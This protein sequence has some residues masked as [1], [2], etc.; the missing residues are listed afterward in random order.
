[1]PQLVYWAVAAEPSAAAVALVLSIFCAIQL[2][3]ALGFE[4]RVPPVALRPSTSLLVALNAVVVGGLGALFIAED[5]G[6]RAA[7]IWLAGLAIAHAALGMASLRYPR[8]A[9]EI[10]FLLLGAAMIG[11]DTAFAFLVD[12]PALAVGWAASAVVLAAVARRLDERG[13][14]LRLPLAGQLALALAHALFID[15]PPSALGTGPEDLAGAAAAVLAVAFGAFAC[16]RLAW[17]E[18]DDM[19]AVLD[20]VSIAAAAYVTAFVLDGTPLVLA[21]AAQAVALAELGRRVDDRIARLASLPFL[22]L[23][24]GHVLV[25]EAPPT[26]LVYG[27]DDLGATAL[28]LGAVAA[29]A[30]RSWQAWRADSAA[31]RTGL[32]AF[33]GLCLLY[34]ASV[35]VVE[36]FQPGS[37]A[38][39]TG[40]E[41]GVRQQGQALLSAL[42]TLSGLA[43]LWV[44]LRR[45]VRELRLAGF[46]LLAIATT[47][48]FLYDLST[49]SSA[50]RVVSF[51]AVGLLLL[52]AALAY[53]RL[54]PAPT[55]SR[56][57]S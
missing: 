22:V 51:I 47:K 6:M 56:A 27:V 50:W 26:A 10:G 11:A 44:G 55:A 53:Q 31:V 30:A 45:G 17:T 40:L 46:G 39:E 19:R 32:A 24:A 28:A 54:R 21:W 52:L 4:V 57:P 33:T 18:S 13:R 8:V 34:L 38:F 42:W 1:V 36:A 12:G 49:L 14:L 16:A 5:V 48:V 29:A 15:A 35:A 25:F 9:N 41:V 37:S 3:V 20:G 2:V 7:G 23:G 43:V